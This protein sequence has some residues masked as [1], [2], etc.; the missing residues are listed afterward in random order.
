MDEGTWQA[1]LSMHRGA[2]QAVEQIIGVET[3]T[4]IGDLWSIGKLEL[5]GA[6]APYVGFATLGYDPSKEK[7]VGTWVDS[8]S[9]QILEMHGNYDDKSSTLTLFYTTLGKNGEL[10]ERKNV[11]V[12]EDE[13]T[14][15]YD[16]YLKEGDEW[17][18][19]MEIYYERID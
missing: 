2:D 16:S 13:N 3:N 15:D 14:R 9:P 6:E 5:P 12:Y 10:E 17:K 7:Y 8:L 1:T 11:M 18:L 19:Y 4:M